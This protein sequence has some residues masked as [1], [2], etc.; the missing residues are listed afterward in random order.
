MYGQL[1]ELRESI[2][3]KVMSNQ[4][5]LKFIFYCDTTENT[6]ILLLPNL[7]KEQRKSLI[8]TQIF[9]YK[10]MPLK[11][12]TT[13][14]CFLSMQYLGVNRNKKEPYWM[15]PYFEFTVV[16]S[17]SISEIANGNRLLAIEECIVNSFDMQNVGAVGNCRVIVSQPT[18]SDTGFQARAIQ[19]FFVDWIAR[20]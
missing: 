20:K 9:K 7:T 11:D 18:N 15:M 10:R 13:A 14:K 16:C 19:V 4:D 1:N 12:E 17:D 8:N 3:N 2:M 6:D 5:L